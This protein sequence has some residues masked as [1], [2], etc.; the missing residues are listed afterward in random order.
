VSGVVWRVCPVN[1]A[2]L[3]TATHFLSRLIDLS[4]AS[5]DTTTDMA[6]MAIVHNARQT[7]G[8]LL[9]RD[10]TYRL[11]GSHA[12]TLGVANA[13]ELHAHA[14]Q[15]PRSVRR[16]PRSRIISSSG[17]PHA[18][19]RPRAVALELAPCA[20]QDN[21]AGSHDGVPLCGACHRARIDAR[22]VGVNAGQRNRAW[23]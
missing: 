21:A 3:P 5:C 17:R 11:S 15:S 20:S 2:Q 18:T 9:P 8:V 22:A 10:E 19:R 14:P 13:H 12:N 1:R 7:R 6:D 23:R 4:H 16:A